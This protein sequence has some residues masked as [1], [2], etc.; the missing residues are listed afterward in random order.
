MAQQFDSKYEAITVGLFC[1]GRSDLYRDE[2][3]IVKET[4]DEILENPEIKIVDE[5]I[6]QFNYV[7]KDCTMIEFKNSNNVLVRIAA[8]KFRGGFDL[9]F[10]DPE[11]GAG[12]RT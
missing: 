8:T 12:V 6:A 10:I 1:A 3:G 4:L 5:N 11:S 2:K 9:W 7:H